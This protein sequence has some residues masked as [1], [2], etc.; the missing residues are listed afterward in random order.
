MFSRQIDKF[1][2][3][4]GLSKGIENSPQGIFRAAQQV[5]AENARREQEA[6]TGPNE[7]VRV[8]EGIHWQ[9]QS[10]GIGGA[11]GT[12]WFSPDFKT[13][14]GFLFVAQKAQGQSDMDWLAPLG[15]FLFKQSLALYGF[16]LFETPNLASAQMYKSLSAALAKN[17]TAFT[18]DPTEARQILNPW[19]QKPL[20]QWGENYPLRQF[21]SGT[22][23][24][25]IA[26]LFNFNGVYIAT[27]GVLQASQTDEVARLGVEL[28]KSQ[29]E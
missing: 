1:L 3:S 20:A 21:Q 12:R 23:F 24:S 27:P 5:G 13:R 25:Q 17:F 2:R 14:N 6:L 29:V 11:P 26:I 18:S 16:D 8:T 9:L 15:K 28:V 4:I 10:I 19:T 7:A 22:R